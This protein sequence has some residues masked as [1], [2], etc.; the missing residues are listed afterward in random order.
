MAKKILSDERLEQDILKYS[1][2]NAVKFN[3]KANAGAV[4][5]KILGENPNLKNDIDETKKKILEAIAKVNKMPAEEQLEQLKNIAPELL[6]H[7]KIE[8][9]YELPAL[10]HAEKGKVITAFPP[11]P[12]GYPHIGHAKG[13]IVNY[14]YAKKYNGRFILR[15]EDTN[16]EFAKK[17]FYE[18]Q[19]EGYKWLGIKWDK[20]IYISDTIEDIYKKGEELI[21]R[22]LFYACDCNV[23]DMRMKRMK[24]EECNCR[25][26]EKEENLKL[27]KA[28]IKGEFDK[29]EI[30]IRLKS[31]MKNP[32]AVMRDPT[33]FRIIKKP[34]E[35]KGTR[36]ILWPSYDLAAA[37]SDGTEG[38][39][40]RVRSKEFEMRAEL[41]NY[42]QKLMGFKQTII[43]EQARFNLEGV[44]ASKRKIRELIAEK[45]LSGWDDPRLSTLAA[46]RRR[47]FSPEGLTNFLLKMS[48]TKHESTVVWENLEAENRK[49]ADKG[50]N[51]YFFIEGPVKITVE[52]AP[53]QECRIDLHPDFKERGERVFRTKN[54]F[55]VAKKDFDELKDEKLYRLMDCLNFEKKGNEFVFESTDYDLF[56]GKGEKIMHWLPADE[57]NLDVEIVM[58]D[59]STKKG[60]GEKDLEKLKADAIIQFERFGF[61]RLDEKKKDKLVFWY[62][63]K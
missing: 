3:G 55:F 31:D 1:L 21:K 34:H 23:E 50:A 10:P 11:E 16:P 51:R 15:F 35:R 46:L 14:E 37:Y 27:F 52:K 41:Q 13:A 5:G 47:G 58:P 20:L 26:R 60:I 9:N 62:T 6:E 42:L 28:M 57:D 22:G 2:N 7:K 4:L 61:C 30:T 36:Y 25:K 38:I 40:H 29:G 43:I 63:H 33:M 45:R 12:S 19:I 59:N 49:A 48:I 18:A 24:G 44:E 32:N 17:E 56:K 39:T 53:E 8:E 54:K